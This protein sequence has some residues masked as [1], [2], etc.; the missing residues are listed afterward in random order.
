[1]VLIVNAQI[2][3]VLQTL[4]LIILLIFKFDDL[5]RGVKIAAL[6]M[7]SS[8]GALS[9]EIFGSYNYVEVQ[10]FSNF[11]PKRLG[12]RIADMMIVVRNGRLSL[13]ITK[14]WSFLSPSASSDSCVTALAIDMDA[15]I[16]EALYF[17]SLC[18]QSVVTNCN[19]LTAGPVVDSG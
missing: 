10:L 15:R 7:L 12:I 14:R 8:I 3:W 11:L 6:N 1:M 16:N 4:I 19:L 18:H 13:E 2:K 5:L 17:R 9:L